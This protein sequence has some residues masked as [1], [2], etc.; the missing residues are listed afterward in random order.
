ME[1]QKVLTSLFLQVIL[2]L[3]RN[4]TTSQLAST[5]ERRDVNKLINASEN[6]AMFRQI[7]TTVVK[8]DF[9]RY[10]VLFQHLISI[11]L[12]A[13]GQVVFRFGGIYLDTD[14]ISVR[15]LRHHLRN[16]FVAFTLEPYNNIQNSIFG[17]RQVHRVHFKYMSSPM[18]HPGFPFSQVCPWSCK[19]SCWLISLWKA[20]CARE[21][22]TDL[23]HHYVC[24][25]QEKAIPEKWRLLQV[26][27]G[28]PRVKMISQDFLVLN[29]TKTNLLIQVRGHP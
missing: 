3:E 28:D 29:R 22:W 26:Q 20:V 18:S 1:I 7:S 11:W 15:P 17:F 10:E 23:F 6:E 4:D 27:F 5:V 13:I 12:Y 2:W 9:L 19:D 16:S 25:L 8:A 21:A 24:E 14:T